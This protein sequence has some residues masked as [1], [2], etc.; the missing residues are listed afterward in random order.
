MAFNF[1]DALQSGMLG[2]A[3]GGVGSGLFGMFGSQNPASS[4]M[5]YE[6][7][8]MNQLP[9]YYQPYMQ[10]AQ[11][12]QPGMSN[13]L[14][15]LM[16]NPGGALNQI[17]SNFHSSPGFNF[18]MRQAMMAGNQSMGA[19]GMAGSPEAMQYN[20]GTA[21]NLANQNYYNY[22]DQAQGLLGQGLQG[23]LGMYGIGAN[24][25]NNLGQNMSDMFNNEAMM[26]YA[27]TQ[28]QNQNQ[29]AGLGGLLGGIGSIL[30][31]IP[32]L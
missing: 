24:A 19:G 2:G 18:A 16:S 25:A 29:G 9:G 21:T 17:G 30:P 23:G 10:G 14:S 8:G 28:Q 27:G 31:M 20:Q 22:T 11:G 32:G 6:Q 1:N 13:T 7:Q 15:G 12:M 26:K 5:P 3:L 4:A